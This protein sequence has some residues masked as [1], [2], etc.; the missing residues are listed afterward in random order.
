MASATLRSEPPTPPPTALTPNKEQREP[1]KLEKPILPKLSPVPEQTGNSDLLPLELL[2]ALK[3]Q[4]QENVSSPKS[5]DLTSSRGAVSKLKRPDS[6][7]KHPRRSRLQHIIEAPP[8]VCG[9]GKDISFLYDNSSA[10]D[11]QAQQRRVII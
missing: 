1:V 9:S 7:W 11:G 8:C 10:Q 5:K 3:R 2:I 6:I 4:P